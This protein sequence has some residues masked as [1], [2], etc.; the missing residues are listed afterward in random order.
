[1]DA[2]RAEQRA[3]VTLRENVRVYAM[4]GALLGLFMISACLS[5]A[6]FEY[7]TSPLRQLI[8]SNFARRALVGLAMGLTAVALIYSRWGKR[9]GAFMNPAM[10]LCFLRL[11]KLELVDAVGYIVAQF[12]G[13]T[14]GVAAC[15][16]LFHAWVSHPAVNYVVTAPGA[17]GAAPAWLA[18]LAIGFVMLTV[19]MSVNR[20]P[21]LAPYTGLFAAALVVL[22]ITF[23]APLS[24]MSLNPARS[25]ASAAIA[26]SFRGFWIYLTAPIAGMLLGVEVQKRLDSRHERLCG[27]LNHSET[28]ACFVRCTCLD[29]TRKRK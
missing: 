8:G 23:E 5:V 16:L 7:P 9:S 29:R 18:E 12:F 19:V 22:F 10:T 25:F 4:D 27:K 6:L 28:V 17:Y 20:V 24:G 26:A 15:A 11:G 21:R 1:M 3:L 2:T 13:G 14:L